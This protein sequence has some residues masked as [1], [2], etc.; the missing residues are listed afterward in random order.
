MKIKCS[1]CGKNF[2]PGNTSNG[3]PNGV[4]FE[5]EDG[6]MINM[7]QKCII[8]LGKLSDRDKDVFFEKL[9][10]DKK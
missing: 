3:L 7:C 9:K 6:T 10:F 2:K 4:G 8:E 5:L 1:V